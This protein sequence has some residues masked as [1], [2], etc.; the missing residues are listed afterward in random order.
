M[1]QRR[2][3]RF[4]ADQPVWITLFGQVDVRIPGRI[5]SVSG[6]GMGLEVA[7]P[8]DT[9]APLKIEASDSLL[10]GEAI[11]CRADRDGFYVG[12]ELEQALHGLAELGERLRQY[13]EISSGPEH[14][15][16]VQEAGSQ[17]QEKT[18]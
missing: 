16:A 6:R 18:R 17:D 7:Q 8:I 1:D 2:E 13:S 5:R 14:A 4:E 9:G 12:V 3:G 11:Y 15:Y 10:L